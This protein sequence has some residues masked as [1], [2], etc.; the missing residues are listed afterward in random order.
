MRKPV[1]VIVAAGVATA[2]VIAGSVS[3]RGAYGSNQ[4]PSISIQDMHRQVNAASMPVTV[5]AEPF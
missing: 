2:A 3:Y 4:L 5:V 1:F